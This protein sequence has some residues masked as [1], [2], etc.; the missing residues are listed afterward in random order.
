[1]CVL[2]GVRRDLGNKRGK[3]TQIEHARVRGAL[4][5]L[6]CIILSLSSN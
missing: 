2:C 5:D 1:V 6:E 3:G 4:I